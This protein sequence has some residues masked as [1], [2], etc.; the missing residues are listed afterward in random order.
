MPSGDIDVTVVGLNNSQG[1]VRLALFGSP[2]TYNND[3][4]IGMGAF[5]KIVV[6]I[7][8]NRAIARF[9]GMPY[10]DYAIKVFHDEN[11]SGKFLTGFFGQPK[12]Q[13]FTSSDKK[14]LF[15]PPSY[16]KARFILDKSNMALQI[17]TRG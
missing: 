13:C 9:E 7:I 6:P 10:G 3:H 11:N 1:V 5:R 12:V 8:G 4:N 16:K 2:E 14:V 17:G 15:W